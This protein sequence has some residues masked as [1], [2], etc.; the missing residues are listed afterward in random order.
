ML[1]SM[2]TVRSASLAAALLL[3]ACAQSQP[4]STTAPVASASA[5]AASAGAPEPAVT[6]SAPA[7]ARSAPPALPAETVAAA[8]NDPG[9]PGVD[10]QFR[11]C[12]ADGDCVAVRRAGCCFNG[13]MEAVARGQEA[14]YAQANACTRVP[15]PACPMYRVRDMRIPK[16]NAPTHLCTLVKP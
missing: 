14:A 1:R 5:P 12:K 9:V 7:V 6:A 13:W 16:C 10:P 4:P 2:A 3:A 15:R 8:S 11:S